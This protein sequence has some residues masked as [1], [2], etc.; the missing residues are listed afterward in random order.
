MIHKFSCSVL[1]NRK[2][3]FSFGGIKIMEKNIS[4]SIRDTFDEAMQDYLESPAYKEERFMI[5]KQFLE[6]R[7]ELTPE[8]A[9]CLNTILNDSDNSNN[10][11]ALEAYT[12]GVLL[13]LTLHE[14][15][16]AM[17]NI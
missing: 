13:G 11:M 16:A 3:V 10:F 5:N 2:L 15:F 8:Q 14:K 4:E 7:K 12:R 1:C 17:M 9:E 6:L